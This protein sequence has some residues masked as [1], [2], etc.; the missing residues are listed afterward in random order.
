M[1]KLL[2]VNPDFFD[3]KKL[4]IGRSGEGM[5][6]K[7]FVWGEKND[8]MYEYCPLNENTEVFLGTRMSIPNN[9]EWF[10]PDELKIDKFDI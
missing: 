2:R 3:E 4:M 10:V 5:V 7:E 9:Q 6:W 1:R 8:L